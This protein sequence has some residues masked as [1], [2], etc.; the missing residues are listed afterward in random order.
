MGIHPADTPSVEFRALDQ[1]QH[2]TMVGQPGL[3]Q[4]PQVSEYLCPAL[5]NA[6]SQLPNHERMGKDLVRAE[7]LAE[8][9]A[10]LPQVVN[11]DRGVS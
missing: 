4:S 11:P 10:A 5:E 6:A 9:G 2:L 8:P 1:V 7:K 3:G